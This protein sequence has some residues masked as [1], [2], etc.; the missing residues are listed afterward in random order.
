M[1]KPS[2]FRKLVRIWVRG[3]GMLTMTYSIGVV[4][5]MGGGNLL[6]PLKSYPVVYFGLGAVLLL[7]WAALAPLQIAVTCTDY[8][9]QREQL[10]SLESQLDHLALRAGVNWT[11]TAIVHIDQ[12]V[13]DGKMDAARKLYHQDFGG[14]WD[15]AASAVNNWPRTVLTKKLELIYTQSFPAAERVE[16]APNSAAALTA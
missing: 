8:R 7:L 4:P 6:S 5:F 12:L 9:L 2:Q 13:E 1:K 10:A 11:G 14:T 3:A 16:Q 15:E